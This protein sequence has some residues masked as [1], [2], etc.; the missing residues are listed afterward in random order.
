MSNLGGLLDKALTWTEID[1]QFELLSDLA[2]M[3]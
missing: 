2:Y 1:I 3:T